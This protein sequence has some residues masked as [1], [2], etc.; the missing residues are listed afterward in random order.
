MPDLTLLDYLALGWFL[1]SWVGYTY[2]AD[3]SRWAG[4]CLHTVMNRHRL[5][6]MTEMFGRELRMLDT[7]ILGTLTSGA[8]FYGSTSI[9]L[10]GGLLAAL[11]ATEVAVSALADL[12]F[13]VPVS[14]AV[15]QL[16]VLLLTT[17]FVYAFFKFAWSFRLVTHCSI[18][19]GAAPQAPENEQVVADYARHLADLAG[20]AAHHFNRGLRAFFF[21]LGALGWFVHPVVFALATVWV[22]AVLQR[23]EFRSKALRAMCAIDA[24][25]NATSPDRPAG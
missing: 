1:A 12:P 24:A 8:A 14:P 7:M 22:L 6:W 10:V 18:L 2:Y 25:R 3:H 20:L 11:G 23:R 21:A 15:W 16:K 13:A 4:T 5:H 19:V 9:L 17:I